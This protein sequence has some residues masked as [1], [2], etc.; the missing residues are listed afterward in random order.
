MQ[1]S[2]Y[3]NK[4]SDNAKSTKIYSLLYNPFRGAKITKNMRNITFGNYF[5][6]F[7][8]FKIIWMNLFEL[9]VN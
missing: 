3:L 2:S 1:K 5:N 8:V 9:N 6:L 7:V 4:N